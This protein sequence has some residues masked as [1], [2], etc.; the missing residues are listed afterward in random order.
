M[1]KIVLKLVEVFFGKSHFGYLN[2]VFSCGNVVLKLVKGQPR[3][4][5]ASEN[6]VNPSVRADL[7]FP[8][9]GA[10]CPR[11]GAPLRPPLAESGICGNTFTG[12]TEG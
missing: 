7:P 11:E 9:E 8:G 5:K 3:G 2:I 1:E 12:D 10:I 6:A 4:R